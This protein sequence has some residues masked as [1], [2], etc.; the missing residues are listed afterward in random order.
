MRAGGVAGV[1]R[2]RVRPEGATEAGR[3]AAPGGSEAG[4]ERAPGAAAGLAVPP[5]PSTSSSSR[6]ARARSVQPQRE[7]PPPCVPR[8]S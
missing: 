4:G 1:R 7:A 8:V 2:N 6:L 5:S 3:A